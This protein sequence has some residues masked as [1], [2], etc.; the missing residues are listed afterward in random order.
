MYHL[1]KLTTMPFWIRSMAV[2][3]AMKAPARQIAD[4]S[5]ADGSAVVERL[6]GEG[7]GIGYDAAT[8]EYIDMIEGGIVDPV[9]VTRLALQCALSISTTLLTAGAGVTGIRETAA[10]TKQP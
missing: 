8:G 7:P 10:S 3:S 5:G 6:L 2:V 4:N 9:K 1:T